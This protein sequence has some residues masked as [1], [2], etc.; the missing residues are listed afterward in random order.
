MRPSN[1]APLAGSLQMQERNISEP[2]AAAATPAS[3]G[4][5]LGVCKAKP[6]QSWV[7]R[8]KA[9][10]LEPDTRTPLAV[11]FHFPYTGRNCLPPQQSGLR[12][13]PF[14]FSDRSFL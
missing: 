12:V 1:L 11:V 14:V 7:A 3:F 5:S 13:N 8:A 2:A 4:Y 6:E 9:G 10:W